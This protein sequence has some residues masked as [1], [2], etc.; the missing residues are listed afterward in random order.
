MLV[1]SMLARQIDEASNEDESFQRDDSRIT[2]GVG[3]LA[4]GISD[5]HSSEGRHAEGSDTEEEK[6]RGTFKSVRG[7]E[8]GVRP[9]RHEL[10]FQPLEMMSERRSERS[11]REP[12]N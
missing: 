3:D 4:D 6:P 12:E 11:R 10:S 9:S 2:A 7:S 5:Q 8:K 1:Q